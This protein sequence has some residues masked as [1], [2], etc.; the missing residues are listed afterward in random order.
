MAACTRGASAMRIA[1]A[2][3]CSTP[4]CHRRRDASRGGHQRDPSQ[5]APCHTFESRQNFELTALCVYRTGVYTCC[6]SSTAVWHGTTITHISWWVPGAAT[7][8]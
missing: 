1:P 4:G 2:Y 3:Y 5:G 7:Y 8:E 6:S